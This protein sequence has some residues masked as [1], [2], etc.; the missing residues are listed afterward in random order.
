MSGLAAGAAMLPLSATGAQAKQP[1]AVFDLDFS[2]GDDAADNTSSSAGWVVD[3]RA[4]EAWTTDSGRLCIDIDETAET[5]GFYRYQGKKY[6]DADG[7]YWYAGR[8]SRLS[9]RFY[10]D[11]AWETDGEAH[12]SGVWPVLGNADGAISAYPIL[13]YQDSGASDTGDAQFR[14]Y[15]Y[16]SDEDGNFVTDK[17]IDLGLPKKLGIDPEEGG[18]VDVEAQLQRFRDGAALKWRINN[19]LVVDERGYNVFAPSTQ[20]L[21]FIFNSINFGKD[22]TYYYDDVV[23]TTPGNARNK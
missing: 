3:R 21:E 7:S 22:A 20:F 19:K 6:Q 14:A 2:D 11:P 18:W 12:E 9:Y 15:V 8:G 10:I 16:E 4:P 23:L 17:W 13:A 5:S 1:N